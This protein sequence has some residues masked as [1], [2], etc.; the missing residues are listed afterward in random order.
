VENEAALARDRQLSEQLP[1]PVET[2]DVRRDT[3][4]VE[5]IGEAEDDLL[6][7]PHVEVIDDESDR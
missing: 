1:F 4:A 3:R 2:D 7:P 5:P 6:E